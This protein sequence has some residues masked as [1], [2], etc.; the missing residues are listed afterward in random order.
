MVIKNKGGDKSSGSKKSTNKM[1]VH[2]VAEANSASKKELVAVVENF[3]WVKKGVKKQLATVSSKKR[4]E[5]DS[6]EE[7]ETKDCF[8]LEELSKGID[9]F[10][11][12]DMEKLT[13]EDS[14]EVS[15]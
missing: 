2:K 14:D 12:D 13:L 8:L 10:N 6:D 9:G 3:K 4:K 11:Y 1:W 15:V 5:S 7:S